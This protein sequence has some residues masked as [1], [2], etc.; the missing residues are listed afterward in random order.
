MNERERDP[1]QVLPAGN[2]PRTIG[3]TGSVL[4]L[5]VV[6][7]PAADGTIYDINSSNNGSLDLD[8]Q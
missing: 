6:L 1:V 8:S 5:R 7:L 3:S 4:K 2:T